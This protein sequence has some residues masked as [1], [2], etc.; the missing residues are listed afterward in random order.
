M[1]QV[2]SKGLG[3][4]RKTLKTVLTRLRNMRA[5]FMTLKTRD[6]KGGELQMASQVTTITTKME[7]AIEALTALDRAIAELESMAAGRGK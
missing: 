4:R 6:W 3:L 2:R 7:E 5:D 1:K